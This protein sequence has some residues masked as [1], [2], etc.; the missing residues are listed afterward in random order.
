MTELELLKLLN[1][2][3]S[4]VEFCRWDEVQGR[5]YAAQHLERM[6]SQPRL[7]AQTERL[8]DHLARQGLVR[9]LNGLDTDEGRSFEIT[10]N[11]QKRLEV[12]EHPVAGFVNDTV[13][14]IRREWPGHIAKW[15]MGGFGLIGGAVLEH[16][17][18]IVDWFSGKV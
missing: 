6:R 3:D 8:L 18:G 17:F 12:L 4:P 14:A 9:A 11:G 2:S 5:N 15:V 7:D 10:V 1:A 16:L 13:K